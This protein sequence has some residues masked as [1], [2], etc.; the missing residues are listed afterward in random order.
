MHTQ[1]L[2]DVDDGFF[3]DV[4]RFPDGGAVPVKARSMVGVVPLL[5]VTTLHPA[6][7]SK[8]AGLH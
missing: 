6:A 2:W 7:G 1:G 3:Y 8:A 5:A 4:I